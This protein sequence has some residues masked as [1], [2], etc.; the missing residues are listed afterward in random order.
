M[1]NVKKYLLW[2]AGLIIT[3]GIILAGLS[4]YGKSQSL[5]QS[6]DSSLNSLQSSLDS[7]KYS[8]FNDN[9][10]VSGNQVVTALKNLASPTFTITVK[11]IASATTGNTYTSPS[12]YTQ[13]DITKSDYIEYTGSFKST[14]KRTSN[15][16]VC[17]IVFVQ[18]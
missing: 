17:G 12:G 5:A 3:A 2:G 13:T 11:T 18:Q 9:S 8:E 4:V 16:T 1:D 6:S 14:L 7:S 15:G 10:I